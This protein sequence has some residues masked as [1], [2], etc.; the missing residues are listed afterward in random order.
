MKT[1]LLLVEDARMFSRILQNRL[2]EKGF[3]VDLAESMAAAKQF[4]EKGSNNYFV[5]ILDLNL[6]DAPEGEIVDYVL[7]GNIPSIVFTSQFSDEVREM[8]VSKQVVDYVTKEDPSSIDYVIDLVVRLHLNQNIQ[9]LVV[10]DSPTSRNYL[11]SL[12]ERQQYQVVEAVDGNQALDVLKNNQDIKIVLTDYMMP[13]LDG[14]GLTKAI[15][16]KHSRN[17]LAVIGI[18]A[19]GNNVLSAK[20]MKNGAS[21]FITKPF[22]VEEFNCRV[23]QNVEIIEYIHA[24]H[25]T[26]VRD[27]LTGLYNRRYFF[28]TGN[29]IVAGVLRRNEP[30]AVSVIDIDNFKNI[31]DTYGHD[32]GDLVLK[33]LAHLLESNTRASDVV[34]RFGG[35]EFC[36]LLVGMGNQAAEAYF[37]RLRNA[38]AEME[39]L[40]DAQTIS[41]T[42]SIGVCSI[43]LSS[44]EE[45]AKVADRQLY[46]AKN[47]GKNRVSI[48]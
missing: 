15:R 24:L 45:M 13:E 21:D 38:V 20:F 14:F 9:V 31:N 48:C 26:A 37:E 44:L 29:K 3:E 27:Y 41:I 10:D 35:E 30:M 33:K 1:K 34:A 25:E 6:P 22:L 43:S 11:R 18:S 8:M 4:L 36:L 16:Q 39:I 28:S 5:A 17:Q 42:I 23:R 7:G 47:K 12:L 32:A 2:L 46:D 40:F 19:H